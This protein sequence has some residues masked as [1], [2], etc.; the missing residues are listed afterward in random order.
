MA[1]QAIREHY[2]IDEIQQRIPEDRGEFFAGF[3]PWAE[4]VQEWKRSTRESFALSNGRTLLR[5]IWDN[6]EDRESR[7]LI[8]V[9]ECVSTADAVE[10][11]GDILQANQLA[12]IPEGPE[13]LGLGSFQHPES[14]PPA[15]FYVHGN[16]AI[17]VTSFGRKP[18]DVSG[19]ASR[20]DAKLGERPIP[21]D[22]LLRAYPMLQV[23][24]YAKPGDE[25]VLR[26]TLPTRKREDSYLKV[27]V[28]GGTIARREG[29]LVTHSSAAGQ[30]MIEAF[31]IDPGPE[32]LAATTT[33]IVR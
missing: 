18:V 5:T 25:V 13:A 22:T 29:Q 2:K 31:L 9:R 7:V 14:A 24:P 28:T 10:A 33:I 1:D 17:T 3:L 20:L 27:F 15:L 21:A 30:I 26:L 12:D 19:I 11:L 8:D 6:P 23:E 4:D 16:L 32:A